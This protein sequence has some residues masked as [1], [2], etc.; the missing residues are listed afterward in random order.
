MAKKTQDLKKREPAAFCID[1]F[2]KGRTPRFYSL[3]RKDED[4]QK[5]HLK[6]HHSEFKSI[7]HLKLASIKSEEAK[8]AKEYYDLYYSEKEDDTPQQVI[9]YLYIATPFIFSA[10]R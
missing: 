2:E 5:R 4:T 6:A 10:R 1:C 3:C 7:S 8:A 9:Y